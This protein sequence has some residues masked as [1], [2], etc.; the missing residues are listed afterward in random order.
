M[1][2]PGASVLIEATGLRKSYGARLVLDGV[3]LAVSAG[4]I[5]GLLGPNGAGKTTT[6]LI[7]ATLLRPDA[8]EIRVAG[9]TPPS[10]GDALR[11]KLGFVP[12]SVALYPSLTGLQNLELFARLHGL[13]RREARREAM[14]VLEEVGLAERA[15][16]SVAVL[17][18]GMKR[19]LDLAC[20]MVHRPEVLLLDEPAVGADPQSREQILLTVRRSASAG[21]GVIY[22]THYMEEVERLCDRVVL[23]DRGRLVAHGTVAELIALAGGHPCL[24]ITFRDAPPPSWCAGISGVS[25]LARAVDS[26]VMVQLASVAQVSE[27]LNGRARR[28]APC[29][30]SAS[31]AQISRTP[32]LR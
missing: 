3:S 18:G 29:S 8:G 23:I 14:R 2:M 28:A 15:H 5:V 13:G 11:R 7:L 9:M 16:D 22:S 20:G 27:L 21:A 26:K 4:E 24:G 17:S 31:T 12:Q 6:L 30:T 25:E 1:S 10:A 19:R 32:L